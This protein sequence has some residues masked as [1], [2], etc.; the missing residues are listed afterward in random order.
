[1]LATGSA[2]KSH[3]GGLR[4]GWVRASAEL[5]SR[6][7]AA[8]RGL[9]LGSPVFEQLL[10]AELLAGPPEPLAERR[11][12]LARHRDALADAVRAQCPDWSFRLPPGG[13]SL[14]CR[15]PAPVSSRIAAVAQNFGVRVVP[16][17]FFAPHGGMERWLRL[18]F[19]ETP[20]TL[21]EAVRRLAHAAVSVAESRA[22]MP[23]D[24]LIQ[25][26]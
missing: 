15:L 6:L 16:G 12:L 2:G 11:A 21:A 26:T 17:S 14:W 20:D 25:V 3:W 19:T 10:F 8:R 22:P 5:V 24:G 23:D 1:V 9:D 18:P 7:V 4:I 13:L